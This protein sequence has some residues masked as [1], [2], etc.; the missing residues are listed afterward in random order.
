M[1]GK[2]TTRYELDN[3]SPGLKLWQTTVTWQN[4]LK[5]ALKK[6]GL[7][8]SQFVVLAV[9]LFLEECKLPST[10]SD[11]VDMSKLGK[12]QISKL[13]S[14]LQ[15][16]GFIEKSDNSDDKRTKLIKLTEEGRQT[17]MSAVVAIE[18]IDEKF[19]GRVNETDRYY[20]T[21]IADRLVSKKP[22][23]AWSKG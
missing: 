5:P 15:D 6:H 13:V 3:S 9:L 12:M 19:F 4:M 1:V 8:H 11:V 10:Q 17:A 23:P 22:G 21:E 20:F 18:N 7:K 2:K 16:K 14:V